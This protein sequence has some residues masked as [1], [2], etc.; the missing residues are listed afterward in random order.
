VVK[1]L[2]DATEQCVKKVHDLIVDTV[3]QMR[4]G[5]RFLFQKLSDEL[6]AIENKTLPP[7]SVEESAEERR[8]LNAKLAA[9]E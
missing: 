8:V 5:V 2:P 7:K 4:R 6:H 3:A 1:T 9:A